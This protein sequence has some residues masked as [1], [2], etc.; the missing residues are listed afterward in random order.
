MFGTMQKWTAFPPKEDPQME[1]PRTDTRALARHI[2]ERLHSY[3]DSLMNDP[4]PERWVDLINR[5]NSE[6][7]KLPRPKRKSQ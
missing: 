2:G 4:L 6:E 7:T 1:V 3:F 5:L